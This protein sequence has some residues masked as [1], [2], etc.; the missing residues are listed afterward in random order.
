MLIA[1][2]ETPGEDNIPAE[3]GGMSWNQQ[4]GRRPRTPR[5]TEQGVKTLYAKGW[6]EPAAKAPKEGKSVLKGG[7]RGQ[8]SQ[9]TR[10]SGGHGKGC[11]LFLGTGQSRKISSK[12]LIW[13]G[14]HLGRRMENRPAQSQGWAKGH[15]H[16]LISVRKNL[17]DSFPTGTGFLG[18]YR[19]ELL[20]PLILYH[21]KRTALSKSK[22]NAQNSRAGTRIEKVNPGDV[23]AP[24]SSW[25]WSPHERLCYVIAL[26][27]IT[28][29][30][31]LS[32]LNNRSLFSWSCEVQNQGAG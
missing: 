28:K 30:H 9:T 25:T 20:Q 13:L 5:Q 31:R 2:P 10:D 14:L 29:Y 6:R 22:A 7:R 15:S 8:Q 17:R 19:Q 1:Y 23:W 27:A 12:D 11:F 24:W 18:G 26:A 32:S 16:D 3:T 21:Y 4:S